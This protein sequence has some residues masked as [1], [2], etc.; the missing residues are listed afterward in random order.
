[1]SRCHVVL[2]S[3]LGYYPAGS[4]W[5]WESKMSKCKMCHGVCLVLLALVISGAAGE[6]A[7]AD[8]PA[9]DAA[10]QFGALEFATAP[11]LSAD[12]KR[13]SFISHG[14]GTISLVVVGGAAGGELHAITH[15]DGDPMRLTSCAWSALDRLVCTAYGIQ[16]IGVVPVAVTRLLAMDADGTHVIGLGQRDTSEQ[17]G[18]RQFDGEIIDW[19]DGITGTVLVSRYYIP[20]ST[21]GRYTA[22][23]DNGLG[24][25]R[26]DTRT[27][28]ATHV[29]TPA[30]TAIGYLS[31][32]RGEVRVA[33]YRRVKDETG[34]L[35]GTVLHNFRKPGSRNWL[36]LGTGD[37][38]GN[39]IEPLAVDPAINAAY[40]LQRLDGRKA[41]YRITLDGSMR[42]EL[43]LANDAVD[44]GDVV[45]IGRGGRVI[46]ATYATDVSHVDYF[47]PTY[48]A[49]REQ[50]SRVMPELPLVSFI[51]ASADEKVLLL[52]AS[53]DHDP[54]RYFILDR[55][56]K[57]LTGLMRV[58]PE[59]A[60]VKLA[61]VQAISFAADDGTK[62]PA[63]LTLPPGKDSAKGLPAV[64]MPH[65]GPAERDV[66]GF[67]WLAQFY[68]NR[69]FAVLQPNFRGSSG[70]GD[71]WFADNGFRSWRIAVGDI[72]SGGR[73]LVA[74]G[75]ADPSKLA[76]V[77]WS[78]GGYA[79]LQ[80]NVLDPGL[81][82]AVV[83]IAPVTDLNLLK[84]EHRDY[85]NFRIVADYVGSGAH[86]AEGSPARHA[87]RFQ[88]PVLMFH[89]EKDLNVAVAESHAM[90]K[91]LRAAGKRSE[92]V[93]YPKLDHGLMDGDARAD[94]LR[95]SDAFLRLSLGL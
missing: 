20:E 32:G 50:L 44:I 82:K 63:Y 85:T 19:L 59:L 94:M 29:E 65:G 87:D 17:L 52:F 58:R 47:D 55:P 91:A 45:T 95:R 7:F 71:S 21:I 43:A 9:G 11:E 14:K 35:T 67:D 62:I 53:S 36:P 68:A 72:N 80:A 41:L 92:L 31:D 26:I 73:W 56:S 3:V 48:R 66:W 16:K 25:D 74:Q 81:Y 42:T 30:N 15:T 34:L 60:N 1:M 13:L 37:V 51:S 40:V 46:G 83:A 77:G 4:G 6:S 57:S 22:Q 38:N 78:Y 33:T 23:T 88:A 70:Y 5:Q 90:D 10:S 49:L 18:P 79:A 84:E 28:L 76:I 2:E 69:G 86:V 93:V 8:D 54:G 64:V 75:I 61:R 24:V 39:G 12:G 89:G 27:G